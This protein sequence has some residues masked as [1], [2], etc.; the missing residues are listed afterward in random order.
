VQKC[1]VAREYNEDVAWAKVKRETFVLL[2]MQCDILNWRVIKWATAVCI[3]FIHTDSTAEL[4]WGVVRTSNRV[5]H[6][7][8]EINCAFV[9]LTGTVT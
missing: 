4:E 7:P 1:E 5:K 2:M 8:M 3:V 9:G 6:R